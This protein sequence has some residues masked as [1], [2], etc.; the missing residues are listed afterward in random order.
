[1]AVDSVVVNTNTG[2]DGNSYTSSISNDELTN[3]DF[4]TLMIQELKLQDPTSPMDSSQMLSTQMQMSTINTNQET[5]TT[6]KAL[7]ETFSQSTLSNAANVI[8]KN[9]EDGNIGETGI[10]K[11]YTVRSVENYDG[12][13]IV[14]AQEIL[15][16]EDKIKFTDPDD[17]TNV[18]MIN[19]NVN[20]EITDEDGNLTGNKVALQE[21]GL[22]LLRDGKPV[23]LDENNVEIT[24]HNYELYG[25]TSAVYSDEL[26]SIPFTQITKIF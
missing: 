26:S 1:M 10:S 11:A 4:L 12:D 14:K 22:P 21:A 24:D 2:V 23:I 13:V 18:S 6:M 9:I 25:A 3:E 7:Q 20:G 16:M 8:G 5:I 17:S 19:Y 15:Y